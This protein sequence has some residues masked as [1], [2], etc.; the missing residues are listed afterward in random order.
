MP[1]RDGAPRDAEDLAGLEAAEEELRERRPARA[2]VLAVKR[3][4]R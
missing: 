1:G 2:A 3:L 4:S